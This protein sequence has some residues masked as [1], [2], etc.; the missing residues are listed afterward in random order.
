MTLNA[1]SPVQRGLFAALRN[2]LA[3]RPDSEHGQAMIRI[4][5]GIIGWL[6]LFIMDTSGKLTAEQHHILFFSAYVILAAVVWRQAQW[7]EQIP[8]AQQ[9]VD[10]A[11]RLGPHEISQRNAA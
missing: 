10:S 5:I 6:Y 3:Q 1:T 8:N 11:G 7:Q 4:A 9:Q 2:R